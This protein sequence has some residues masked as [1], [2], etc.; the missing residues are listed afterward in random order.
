MRM[1]HQLKILSL[2]RFDKSAENKDRELHNSEE[3]RTDPSVGKDE[4]EVARKVVDSFDKE[5]DDYV[6]NLMIEQK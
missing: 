6:E 4:A 2:R 3:T 1:L 5:I